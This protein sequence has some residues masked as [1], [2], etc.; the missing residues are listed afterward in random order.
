MLSIGTC[1]CR[2]NEVTRRIEMWI[3]ILEL[4]ELGEYSAVEL[5][6]AKDVNT[7][8]IFQLRQVWG[9][10]LFVLCF[11]FVPLLHTVPGGFLITG[12]FIRWFSSLPLSSSPIPCPSHSGHP[13]AC[14]V[15]PHFPLCRVIPGEC[16]SRWNRCSIPGHC[17]SWSKPSCLSPLA[18]SL[19]DPLSCREGW[20]VTR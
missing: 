16:K 8:G 15:L 12:F 6:Q 20:T 14:H 19:P 5:H 17:R 1:F 3:S 10:V 7:G 4:N 2:W 9:L 13:L 18:A 11:L